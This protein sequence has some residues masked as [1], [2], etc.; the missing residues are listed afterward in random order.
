MSNVNGLPLSKPLLIN[1]AS[2]LADYK[3][4]DAEWA[5]VAEYLAYMT[6]KRAA[7]PRDKTILVAGIG[8]MWNHGTPTVDDFVAKNAGSGG[9][10]ISDAPSDGKAYVRKDGAWSEGVGKREVEEIDTKVAELDSVVN[11]DTSYED[12]SNNFV[13]GYYND[14]GILNTAGANWR[15]LSVDVEGGETFLI[16][17]KGTDNAGHSGFSAIGYF[18]ENSF[19]QVVSPATFVDLEEEYKVP[20]NATKVVFTTLYNSPDIVYFVKRESISECIVSRM[21]NTENALAQ[22][23]SR[24]TQAENRLSEGINTV[25]SSLYEQIDLFANPELGYYKNDGSW[26]SVGTN[27]LS[28]GKIKVRKGD[29]L[30]FS[31]VKGTSVVSSYGWWDKLGAYHTSEDNVGTILIT[32]NIA[33]IQVSTKATTADVYS[34]TLSKIDISSKREYSFF[35][36]SQIKMVS[37]NDF[38]VFPYNAISVNSRDFSLDCWIENT[39]SSSFAMVS[40]EDGMFIKGKGS[41]GNIIDH[42]GVT[43]TWK[44]R[45]YDNEIQT[46]GVSTIVAKTPTNPQSKLYVLPIGDSVTEFP[47]E[48]EQEEGFV[49]GNGRGAWV[50]E[51]SRLLNGIGDE[52]ANGGADG[53]LSNVE[54]IGTRGNGTVK[55][56]GRAGWQINTYLTE[57]SV[58]G[59]SN[60]FW[61]PSTSEFDMQYYL[62]TNGFSGVAAS[63]NN[64]VIIIFLNWNSVY[65]MTSNQFKIKYLEFIDLI[66]SQVPDAKIMMLGM[67]CPP[68][69]LNKT[70]SGNRIVSTLGIMEQLIRVENTL[71]D[72]ASERAS[73]VKHQPLLP[74]FCPFGSYPTIQQRVN[75]RLTNTDTYYTDYVH[76]NTAGYGQI[77]DIV[78]NAFCVDYL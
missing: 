41:N 7:P 12:L 32:D 64:L 43:L 5:S 29:I 3:N 66:H 69:K 45:N 22:E 78:Y 16:K 26:Q 76:P 46:I 55:H 11:G 70:Y 21:T 28:T 61:N 42:N 58:S 49:G 10:G 71:R 24:A 14:S 75:L 67:N 68:S 60:A 25:K 44:V 34:A 8:E 15:A 33:Y 40:C 59:V 35:V 19:V 36:P 1:S 23:T 57:S 54:V 9:S 31:V 17:L 53:S 6:S 65:S 20:S 50:N 39:Q 63:G 51:F 47:S 73:F 27:W 37:G 62:Q 38:R 30:V 52:I 18:T 2:A 56:E 77:A 48:G 72:I 74:F 13:V 4:G